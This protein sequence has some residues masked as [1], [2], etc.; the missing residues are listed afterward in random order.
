[1][2][3]KSQ[4][5]FSSSGAADV[6]NSV[7]IKNA[8]SLVLNLAM[9]VLVAVAISWFFTE[10]GLKSGMGNMK[11]G[12]TGC[13]VFFT[14]DSNILAALCSLLMVPFNIKAIKS[15][16][17]EIPQWALILK[18]VGTVAV[19]VT[20]MVVLLFLGPTAGYAPMFE[21]NCLELHLICPLIAI[22]SFCFFERGIVLSKKQVLWGIV[23]TIIYGTVYLVNVVFTR[24]WIDFYGFNIGGYW[25]ISYVVLP[26]VT[27]LF[28]LALRAIHN[29]SE[30][31]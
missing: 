27:Y 10:E 2:S 13:F 30:R 7:K 17:N 6:K 24:V 18:F 21:G 28:A 25:Y 16:R 12:G 1:M 22:V 20:L 8:V 26:A 31:I 11:F 19:T 9:A 14:N 4:L 29:K 23:P 3:G 15:G 5:N